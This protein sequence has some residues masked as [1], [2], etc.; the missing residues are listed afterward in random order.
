MI[1]DPKFGLNGRDH[2]DGFPPIPPWAER[3]GANPPKPR[4]QPK[5]YSGKTKFLAFNDIMLDTTPPDLVQGIIPKGGMTTVWGPPKCGKSFWV[6]DLVMHVA[7]GWE[8][9]G[10]RVQQGAI[11]YLALEG[12]RGFKS[13]IV[14]W[15]EKHATGDNPVPFY[16]VNGQMNMIT[17]HGGLIKDI[18][19][20]MRGM[21]PAV[22][23]IDTLNRGLVG[24]E[25]KPE[26]MA[27]FISAADA[28]RDAFDCAVIIVHHCG[29]DGKRPRGHTSLTGADDAEIAVSRSESG[30]ITAKVEL[31]KDGEAG[32]IIA[33]RLERSQD[34][35][36]DSFGNP[37]T[38]MIIAPAE[39][40]IA[41][42]AQKRKKK[43]PKAAKISLRALQEAINECGEQAP[44]CNHIPANTRVTTVDR[45]RD[46]AYRR[47]ISSSE[48][49]RAKQTAF[50]RA[51]EYILGEQAATVWD[52]Y[53]WVTTG[54]Q[55]G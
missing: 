21:P 40:E 30:I 20:F 51:V 29:I 11:I 23:V 45:W 18:T 36:T 5:A 42:P 50:K 9:R 43:F 1:P 53:V 12:G 25:N 31:M 32:A 15:R 35:G 22:V 24:S 33:S 49:P 37:I 2:D 41:A 34:L 13:R 55:D 28:I 38:S 19:E 48:E 44:A 6:T 7:L 8:Y 47:G 10:R 54:S 26:D 16:L 27:K 14:A 4:P 3:E 39:E 46:Y 17:E 52:E